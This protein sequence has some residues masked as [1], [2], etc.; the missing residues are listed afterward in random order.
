M[1][2]VLGELK[3]SLGLDSIDFTKGMTNVDKR[4]N[5]LNTEFKAISAGSAKFDN[6][7]DTLGKRADVLTRTFQTHQAKVQELKKR[8]D[9]SKASSGENSAETLRLASAYNRAYASMK[10]TEDQLGHV[11]KELNDVENDLRNQE[12]LWD[13]LSTKIDEAGQSMK[14]VGQGLTASVT[15]P[16]AGL[17]LAASKAA[18]DFDTAAGQIQA[19]IG[20]T[21]VEAQKLQ[22][23]A[24]S[25]WE[26]G[27]GQTISDVT[28]KVSG[29]GKALGYL[30]KVDLSYVT[31][32][33]DLF[34]NR[35]WADQQ[36]SLRAIKVLM[37]QFGMSAQEATDYLT[38]GFQENLNYSGE[39]LDTV[40]EYSTY[41]KEFGFDADEM[42]T[43]L[44][45]GAESGAFQLDKVGDAMKEFSLRAKDGSDTSKDA[46]KALGLNAEV[47]TKEFNKGGDSAK[48]AFEKVVKSL[49]E[50]DD[51]TVRNTATV[52]LFGT[53]FEDLGEKAFDAMLEASSGLK[54]V[55]GATKKAS[56]ALRDNFGTRATKIWRD[57]VE[58]M[59]PVGEVL[60]DIAEDVLP[61]VSETVGDVTEAFEDMTPE[62]QKTALA[63][64]GIAVV[65]GPALTVL[66]TM[67]S[68]LGSLT[69]MVSP[70]LPMLGA[71]K[72]FTGILSRIP[73]PV[74]LVATGLGLVTTAAIAVKDATEKAKEVNLEHVESLIDQQNSLADL[75]TKYEVLSE[76]NKLSND[77]LLR[78]RD[79]Q[80]ELKTAKSAEE[81]NAL[82]NEAEKLKKESGLTNDEIT[83]MLRLNDE[84][85]KT[86]PEVNKSYSDRGNAIIEN[87]EAIND[88]NNSLR[89]SIAL[90]LENQRIKAEA[91]L[92]Q[93]I[94]DY[95]DALDE[96]NAKTLERQEAEGKRDDLEKE[97]IA[98]RLK[99]QEE[100]NSGKEAYAQITQD[101]IE[102][103][104]ME[105]EIQ[106]QKVSSVATEVTEKQKSV[107]Q[108]QNEISK[109]QEL[110]DQMINL[111]LAQV[112]INEKGSEG[113]SQL[114]QAIE[115]SL[116]RQTELRKIE[117]AQ[118]GLNEKQRE[119]LSIIQASLEKYGLAKNEIQQMQSEQQ[120][121]NQ[122]I[123]EGTGKAKNLT[124]ELDKD[125]TKNVKVDDNGGANNLQRNVEKGANKNINVD[126]NGKAKSIHDTASKN[127]RKTITISGIFTAGFRGIMK[128]IESSTG[129][130]IPGF[131]KGTR[132]APGGL[133]LVGEEGPELIHLPKGARVIPNNDTEAILKRWNIPMMS[134]GGIALSAGMAYVGEKG[135]ELLDI[136]G[137]N[138][139]PLSSSSSEYMENQVLVHISPAPIIFDGK[140]VAKVTFKYTSQLQENQ[141][142]N[143]DRAEGRW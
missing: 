88:I 53:Q 20:T 32:G 47:M 61:K 115:K 129:I 100:L 50:T 83:E 54:G 96:L 60:L 94:R 77:E 57:F 125:V 130:N 72:G 120:A 141:Q 51:E 106:N 124:N 143:L 19:E 16:M 103:L 92:D 142:K 48:K 43:K 6:S 28:Q 101:E 110:F 69:K 82:K 112:G 10:R 75:S 109:T 64:G 25:L 42:F 33:L 138:T 93:N 137:A 67:T 114:D 34:E 49:Q 52:G 105:L 99:A 81:I 66:G 41:F 89:E 40:S 39:F 80:S 13:K 36:E 63:I 44:K 58:D 118:G 59:E 127:A 133:S 45:S 65:A 12:N 62:G 4:I 9:E 136:R 35:G 22:E 71:G 26:E 23:I 38:K 87:K 117:E 84:I 56:D 17:A 21:G 122:R 107:E 1:A 126:D 78:F 104:E 108:T 70:L 46:F 86:A 98:L 5:A 15:L 37:E 85:I 111:Q 11:K 135:R 91:N 74:G 123:D 97:I 73:G 27:F 55:E 116:A 119:E 121:V 134:T 29:V 7:L 3:I 132:R 79:I 139:S 2:E 31:K 68:G 8:Y 30:N 24:E 14:N 128:G 95:I 113:I 76:K 102:R 90:E 18:I 140:E 131:K